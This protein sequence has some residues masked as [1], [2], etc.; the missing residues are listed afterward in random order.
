MMKE[1]KTTRTSF[2]ELSPREYMY[3]PKGTLDVGR[4]GKFSKIEMLHL[5]ISMAVLTVAFSLSFT[6]NNI[7]SGISE[8]FNVSVLPYGL[9][10]SFV[11]IFTAFFVH[12]ISHKVIAQ[13]YGLW[14]EFRMFPNGLRLAFI[15]G[16]LTPIVIAAPGAVM[17]RGETRT[18]ETGRIAVA[19][20]LANIMIAGLTLVLYRVFFEFGLIGAIIGFICLVNVLLATFNLLPYGPLDGLKV[21]RWNG[22]V[23]SILLVIAIIIF[24][25]LYEGG[26]PDLVSIFR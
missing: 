18:F 14:A 9:V 3:I 21:L 22:I 2:H 5:L 26:I 16:I 20:P 19:G 4:P 24:V 6:G 23:W 12:E 11:G 13:R 15:L 1:R 7:Y 8:G 17:F 10:M 25:I